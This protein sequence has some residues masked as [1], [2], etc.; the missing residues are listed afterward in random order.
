MKLTLQQY[1]ALRYAA[2][3]HP[4]Q[5]LGY[6]ANRLAKRGLMVWVGPAQGLRD[7]H[8][9]NPD[10]ILWRLTDAGQAALQEAEQSGRFE[11]DIQP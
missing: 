8:P 10:A 11:E 5:P 7:L 2:G 3:K 9:V 6:V 1:M 4:V